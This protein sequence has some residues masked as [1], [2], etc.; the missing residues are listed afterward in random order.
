MIMLLRWI[1]R[2]GGLLAL[3]LGLMLTRVPP[4]A[5]QI[6]MTLGIL[7]CAALGILA[8]WALFTGVRIP[9]AIGGILWAAL[10]VYV[11]MTQSF[12]GAVGGT[13]LLILHPLLGVGA[14]GLAEMLAAALTRKR[15]S[16]A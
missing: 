15:A 10:T 3:L 4:P 1:T 14:I 16:L 7:V 9:A 13:G 8:L 2:I 12:L 11:G 5:T 6:H